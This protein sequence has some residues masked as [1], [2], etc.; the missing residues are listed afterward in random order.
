MKY[1][2]LLIMVL[3]ILSTGT[4]ADLQ[5]YPVVYQLKT[6]YST[7]LTIRVEMATQQLGPFILE[8]SRKWIGDNR[9]A[10][11]VFCADDHSLVPYNTPQVCSLIYWNIN[12]FRE[13]IAGLG[14]RSDGDYYLNNGQWLL[15]E[16][17]NFPR[18]R[19]NSKAIVCI[20][21]NNCR[22]LSPNDKLGNYLFIIWGKKPALVELA[23]IKFEIF[24]DRQAEAVDKQEL[25]AKLEPNIKYLNNVFMSKMGNYIKKPIKI[26]MLAV[27]SA[28]VKDSGGLAGDHAFLV[29]YYVKNGQVSLTEEASF[30][31][32]TL[33]EYIHL[34]APCNLFARW[35]C[36]SLADYYAFKATSLGKINIKALAVWTKLQH[37]DSN[38]KLG[39]YK[40]DRLQKQTSQWAYYKLFYAKG[41]S[42]WNE[43]DL[44][45]YRKND[46]L[47]NYLNLLINNSDTY[48]SNLPQAFVDKMIGLLGEKDFNTLASYYLE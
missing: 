33:H 40:I 11:Q 21:N 27:N 14:S 4:F 23:G 2:A 29:N 36:E 8:K 45:L 25:M 13:P 31:E 44:L 43:L 26:V 3:W 20:N 42:F 28:A 9:P 15:R 24:T 22:S 19:G 38:Y 35:A 5:S 37:T 16:S 6:Y 1:K 30:A 48:Q 10:T 12:F 41:A 39:L 32:V 47:D 7:S 17:N 18:I 34:L 46:T